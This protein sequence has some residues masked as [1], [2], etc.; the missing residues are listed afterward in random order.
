MLNAEGFVAECTGDNVF[1]V[2]ENQLLTP[3]A[4]GGRAILASRVEWCW[5]WGLSL[6]SRWPKRT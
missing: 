4:D 6:G 3:P 5:T 2:K 1:I